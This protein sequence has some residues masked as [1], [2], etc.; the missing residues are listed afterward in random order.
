MHKKPFLPTKICSHCKRPFS[1]RKKWQ[2]NWENVR[3]CSRRCRQSRPADAT[4]AIT[5][6]TL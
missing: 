4:D 6:G 5:K 2:N 1:W 3:Y